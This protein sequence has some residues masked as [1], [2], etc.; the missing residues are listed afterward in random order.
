MLILRRPTATVCACVSLGWEAVHAQ[1]A[2][3]TKLPK[4]SN[5]DVAQVLLVKEASFF[6]TSFSYPGSTSFAGC[7]LGAR[8]SLF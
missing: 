5:L 4:K 3:C 1:L 6:G 8:G 2:I 7:C